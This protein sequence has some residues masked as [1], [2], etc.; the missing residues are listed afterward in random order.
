MGVTIYSTMPN[1][2]SSHRRC[3][4]KKVILK[5]FANF[6]GK[7]F[8]NFAGKHLCWSLK[9][10]KIFK[11]IYFEEHLQKTVSAIQFD[12]FS[13]I[14]RFLSRSFSQGKTVKCE[15]REIYLL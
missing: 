11:N 1:S 15:K 8:A 3:S 10:C 2:R 13:H 4:V 12:N 6:A 5:N 14:L 9:I 7:H